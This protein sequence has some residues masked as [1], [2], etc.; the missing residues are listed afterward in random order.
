MLVPIAG[1]I[2]TVLIAYLLGSIP[3]GFLVARA[4]GIDI[5]TVGSGNIGATNVFRILGKPAGILVLLADAAKGWLAVFIVARLISGWSYPDAGQPASE[6]FRL[7]AGIAA[8]LGHNYSCWLHFK[9]GKGI[10]TSAGV[11]VALVPLP[12]LII[13]TIWILVFA[14][15]RYVS[16]ASIAASFSLPFAAWAVGISRTIVLVTAGL[17]EIAAGAIAMGLGGFLAARS[18]AEHY[19]S[20]RRR[21][22]EE[23]VRVPKTEAQEIT[24]IFRN[25]GIREEE[26]A[27]VVAA[28]QRGNHRRA[29]FLANAVVAEDVR[30]LLRLGLRDPDGLFRFAATFAGVVLRVA[31]RGQETAQPHGNRACGDLRQ[32]GGDENNGP[33][34]ANRPGGEWQGKGGGNRGE[35]HVAGKRED[36]DPDGQNDQQRQ[37]NERD[38]H[39]GGSGNALA[40][41]EMKPATVVVAENGSDARAEAEPFARRLTGIRIR[42]T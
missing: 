27:P 13:L 10:A 18:D 40:A 29:L 26:S 32:T 1:Y 5:R 20:E 17:A 34:Y 30:D 39:P 6:W 7:C 38:Q 4:R 16:L 14:F 35:R 24:D 8:I 22:A 23:T 25:Y 31:A 11:L 2:L 41:L 28:L 36:E 12:L 19:A 33:A 15:T 21:E 3:T 9:G 37:W 42:P